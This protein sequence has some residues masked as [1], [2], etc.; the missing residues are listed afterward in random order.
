M[1]TLTGRNVNEVYHNA[2]DFMQSHGV[3]TPSR[4]G[5]TLEVPEPV[6]VCY[7]HPM[8][9]LLFDSVR[10]S[11]PFLGFFESLWILAGRSDVKFLAD[12]VSNMRNYSDDG[13]RFYGA[14]GKRLRHG[15][16]GRDSAGD[17]IQKAIDRLKANPDDRRVVMMIRD[18]SDM[19][20]DGKDTPCNIAVDCKV[21][22]GKLNISV[23]NR[24]NDTIWGMLGTN[25][26]QFSTLQEY[27]AGAIGVQVGQYHQITT[28]MHVYVNK[29]WEEI[30]NSPREA[31]S[32]Y[33]WLKPYGMY[34]G[35]VYQEDLD[36]DIRKFFMAVD[37]GAEP[38]NDFTTAYF[39]DVVMPLW[40]T[41]QRWRV[42]RQNRNLNTFMDVVSV[43]NNIAAGDLKTAVER[44]LNRREF[45]E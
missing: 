38:V 15:A 19:W 22:D 14:Y 17:Q 8:E 41:L 5:P 39:R 21:R 6:G 32:D 20:Y 23:F 9:R 12:I 2:I 13:H 7:Q 28:S 27:M 3:P 1:L 18:P 36:E 40:A 4:N 24:S 31:N 37:R 25:V 26:V 30:R 16:P 43:K 35:G 34:T 33:G 11:N 42:Y 45:Y 29:Q 10:D 44:W